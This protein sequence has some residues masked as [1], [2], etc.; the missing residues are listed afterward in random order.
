MR[1]ES[2]IGNNRIKEQLG[3]LIDAN[4]FP[5]ALIIEGEEGLGKKTLAKELAGALVCSSASERPCGECAD[6]KK[7]LKNVHPD[8]IEKSNEDGK[9]S[10]SIDTVREIIKDAYIKPN[11]AQFKVYILENCHLMG[12]PAQNALLK[13]IEEPPE[14][15]VFIM[16]TETKS[17]FLETVLSRSVVVTLEGV[18]PSKA[19]QFICDNNS[20]IDYEEALGAAAICNGN[21]GRALETLSDGKLK[22]IV[23]IANSVALATI[24][25]NEYELIKAC[26]VFAR[27][28][29]TLMDSLTFLKSILRDALLFESGAPPLSNQKETAKKLALNLSSK[30]LLNMITVCDDIN[31]F[32]KGNGNNAL[33]ITKVC[34][35]LRRA[36]GR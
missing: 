19:A 12:I 8:I 3:A 17:A 1:F 26:A 28:N 33:L 25:E 18:E 7:A 36:Q 23:E 4:R 29:Q 13:I 16:L 24:E 9:R 32:A 5:H 15:A 22:R 2:F 34:Y 10:F 30:K 31:A 27:D 21:I 20:D 11:E 14:Y 35:E 6:C